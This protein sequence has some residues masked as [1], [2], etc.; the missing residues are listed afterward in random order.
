[1][2]SLL[3]RI[4][5]FGQPLP[6]FNLNGAARVHTMTG[7]LLSFFIMIVFMTYGTLKFVQL[8]DKHNP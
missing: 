8:V 7:G 5:V 3:E 2:H 6:S 1:M 4:D